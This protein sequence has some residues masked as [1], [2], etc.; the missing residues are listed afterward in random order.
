MTTTSAETLT[1]HLD[2]AVAGGDLRRVREALA[3]GL[4]TGRPV[5]VDLS[6]VERPSSETV[7]TILWAHRSCAGRNVTFSIVGDR[8]P[9]RRV[10]RGCGVV[11]ED[12]D[13]C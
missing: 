5:R 2:G 8:G 7:A 1:V 3:R 12:A 13:A 6:G 9:T 4:R 11:V 10:L